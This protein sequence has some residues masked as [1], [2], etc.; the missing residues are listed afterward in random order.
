V[1]HASGCFVAVEKPFENQ[2]FLKRAPVCSQPI[3]ERNG[4][5]MHPA[6]PKVPK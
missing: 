4:T 1:V 3:R 6:A 2:R 5:E